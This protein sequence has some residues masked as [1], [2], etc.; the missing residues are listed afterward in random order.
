M[1]NTCLTS[2]DFVCRLIETDGCRCDHCLLPPRNRE[3][4]LDHIISWHSAH[5]ADT[6]AKRPNM[7]LFA[8][9]GYVALLQQFFTTI[10]AYNSR[11]VVQDR[12]VIGD[13]TSL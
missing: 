4:C 13:V 11:I 12:D 8:Q 6:N 2:L 7:P 1:L 3:R 9:E 10:T 5:Y